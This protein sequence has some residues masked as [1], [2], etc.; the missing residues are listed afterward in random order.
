MLKRAQSMSWRRGQD[1]DSDAV[2][3]RAQWG[4]VALGGWDGT[5][6]FFDPATGAPMLQLDYARNSPVAVPDPFAS[7][8]K[9][10]TFN[11]E[12]N[13]SRRTQPNVIVTSVALRL[14]SPHMGT[15]D[16]S[17]SDDARA[18]PQLAT[19]LCGR[20]G[21]G[22]LRL[23]GLDL[24]WPSDED[25]DDDEEGWFEG[26]IEGHTNAPASASELTSDENDND[27]DDGDHGTKPGPTGM[28]NGTGA[29][30]N[31][32]DDDESY[33]SDEEVEEGETPST[34]SEQRRS[35]TPPVRERRSTQKPLARFAVT[36]RGVAS[37]AMG[38]TV[39]QLAFSPD[40]EY[41]AAAVGSAVRLVRCVDGDVSFVLRLRS[42]T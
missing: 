10:N 7:Q 33:N 12:R 8:A 23:Y 16:A 41:L 17:G 32:S 30:P 36:A 31:D 38:A 3:E 24:D 21:D 39:A 28:G 20:G 11:R 22:V 37:H 18:G 40:G 13:Q 27:N 14:P 5:V 42:L 25:S 15:G 2:R 34:A 29:A 6:R 19:G 4:L 9:S 1:N 35:A 26:N